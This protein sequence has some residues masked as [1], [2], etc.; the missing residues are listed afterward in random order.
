MSEMKGK[1][2]SLSLMS[3]QA[4]MGNEAHSYNTEELPCFHVVSSC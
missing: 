1:R 3:F 2:H 4:S